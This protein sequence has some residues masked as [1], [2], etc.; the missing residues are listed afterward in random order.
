MATASSAREQEPLNPL[1]AKLGSAVSLT[2][3]DRRA[4]AALGKDGRDMGA[5]RH[6]IREGDR[7]DFVHLMLE[8]WAARYKLLPDGGRQITAFLLPGD[9]CDLHVAL[10]GEMD[11]GIA[12]LSRAR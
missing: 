3:R 8:G 4:L 9:F 6:L 7:P 10:L 11:H 1:I 12:T 5:R 2:D